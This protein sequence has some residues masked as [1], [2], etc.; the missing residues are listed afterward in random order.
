MYP[1]K[2]SKK[3]SEFVNPDKVLGTYYPSYNYG[4]ISISGPVSDRKCTLELKDNKGKIIWIHEI[5]A[6]EL[7]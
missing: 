6:D 4:E 5:R 7:K 3:S 2:I 1:I